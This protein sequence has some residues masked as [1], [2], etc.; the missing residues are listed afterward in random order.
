MFVILLFLY[1]LYVQRFVYVS[2]FVLIYTHFKSSLFAIST[3]YTRTRVSEVYVLN[4][5]SYLYKMLATLTTI[6]TPRYSE[7]VGISGD[8]GRLLGPLFIVIFYVYD[9]DFFYVIAIHTFCDHPCSDSV[10]LGACQIFTLLQI[11]YMCWIL[12]VQITPPL[13][14]IAPHIC[15]TYLQICT[16]MIRVHVWYEFSSS[17]SLLLRLRRASSTCPLGCDD[18]ELYLAGLLH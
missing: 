10:K 17:S 3:R 14:W 2:D 18:Y 5:W 11:L 9:S 16:N 4:N 12:L 15:V 8:I 7:G 13:E 1:A 6:A